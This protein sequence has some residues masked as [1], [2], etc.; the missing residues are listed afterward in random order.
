M[1][2][3]CSRVVLS[4]HRLLLQGQ[5]AQPEGVKPPVQSGSHMSNLNQKNL[6]VS[7][8]PLRAER[9]IVL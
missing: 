2:A 6:N 3:V 9:G 4:S 8:R 1:T 5:E 7:E